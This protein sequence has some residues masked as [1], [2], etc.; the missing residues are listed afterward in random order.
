MQETTTSDRPSPHQ[1]AILRRLVGPSFA[2][3][4]LALAPFLR[5]PATRYS[6]LLRGI[7]SLD[8]CATIVEIGTWN[9]A[10][11]MELSSMAL[12]K[13]RV[14]RYYGFDLFEMLTDSILEQ[15]VSKRPPGRAQVE[16]EL[17]TFG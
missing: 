6:Q 15:E 7:A 14:V 11:A 12:Q 9:G 8:R 13:N 10:R 16:R 1:R 17:A 2:P 4:R 5:R 3:V